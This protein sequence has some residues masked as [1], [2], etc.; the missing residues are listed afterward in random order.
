[1]KYVYF[2][3]EKLDVTNTSWS[4]SRNATI[5][6]LIVLAAHLSRLLGAKEVMM[7]IDPKHWDHIL[8]CLQPGDV[9]HQIALT[10]ADIHAMHA[11]D[12]HEDGDV[13]VVVVTTRSK[14]ASKVLTSEGARIVR[15]EYD[16]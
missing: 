1:M 2:F 4:S 7:L 8:P 9:S 6:E 11:A 12:G 13:P 3:P 16:R 5:I 10:D 15:I 14:A